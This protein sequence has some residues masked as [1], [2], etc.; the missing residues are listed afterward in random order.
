MSERFPEPTLPYASHRDVLLGYLDYMR[1]R[2]LDK[3]TG[4]PKP[5]PHVSRLSS[6]W[7]PLQLLKHLIFVEH[8]WLEWGFEGQPSVNPWGDQCDGR[9]SVSEHEHIDDLS[10]ALST[11]GERTRAIVNSHELGDQG[12][13][14]LRWDGQPPAT[15]ERVLLHLIQEYARHLGQIDIVAELAGG[16]TG[17]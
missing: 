7:T 16:E 6:G 14:G 15:L 10:Q 12:Q 17:E 1:A 11:Q 5:E 13:P 3:V 4:L 9:W 8:R 2:I